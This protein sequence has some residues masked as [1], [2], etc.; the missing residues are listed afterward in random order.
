VTGIIREDNI[1]IPSGESVILPGD[2]I[3]IFAQRSAIPKVEKILMV[4]LEYF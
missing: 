1:T 3:I 2:R 4:K